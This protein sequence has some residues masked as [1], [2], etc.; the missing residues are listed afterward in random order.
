MSWVGPVPGTVVFFYGGWPF[1]QAAV[2]EVRDLKPARDDHADRD[3]ITSAYVAS[4]L[5]SLAEF[6]LDFWWERSA[7]WT[8]PSSVRV[9]RRRRRRRDGNPINSA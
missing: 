1:L 3:G 8:S 7:A 9:P 4:L 6:D 2:R 5:T